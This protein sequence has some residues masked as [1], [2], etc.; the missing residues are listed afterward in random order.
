MDEFQFLIFAIVSISVCAVLSWIS[1]LSHRIQEL[2]SQVRD[3]DAEL[4]GLTGRAPRIRGRSRI[5]IG[6]RV[7]WR[8]F[9]YEVA[10]LA[11]G[12]VKL[13]AVSS[14]P[15]RQIDPVIPV[16]DLLNEMDEN[17]DGK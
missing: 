14:N 2:Q 11:G 15:D 8:G 16:A 1:I 12:M 3:L 6:L 5:K 9:E 10:D 17:P 7:R 4:D 13:I